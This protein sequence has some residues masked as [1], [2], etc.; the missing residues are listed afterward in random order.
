MLRLSLFVGQALLL[1]G[2]QSFENLVQLVLPSLH[3]PSQFCLSHLFLRPCLSLPAMI[4]LKIFWSSFQFLGL[5]HP[6]K[7]GNS[8]GCRIKQII[9]KAISKSI[10]NYS[11]LSILRTPYIA[12][13]SI[14]RTEIHFPSFYSNKS[15]INHFYITNLRYSEL[16]VLRTKFSLQPTKTPRYNELKALNATESKST[17][18]NIKVRIDC[19][20]ILSAVNVS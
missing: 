18:W 3:F 13:I 8:K 9:N 15:L 10:S 2:C 1:L 6:T 7:Q 14:L 16:S 19:K 11:R 12:N 4:R 20:A 5:F 17:R